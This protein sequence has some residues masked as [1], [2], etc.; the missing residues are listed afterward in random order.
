MQKLM[1]YTVL[2]AAAIGVAYCVNSREPE[3]VAQKLMG[4]YEYEKAIALLAKAIEAD[5]AN[6]KAHVL[7][8]AAFAAID[9]QTAAR[10]ELAEAERLA[11]DDPQIA[12]GRILALGLLEDYAAALALCD[13]QLARRP[14]AAELLANRANLLVSL[15]RHQQALDA[16]D[17]AI[18]EEVSFSPNYA[19]MLAQRG[20]LR[21]LMNDLPG[22]LADL[23]DASRRNPDLHG[24]K[25]QRAVTLALSG[26][27]AEAQAAFAEYLRL[28]PGAEDY[29]QRVL[30]LARE[31]RTPSVV[32]DIRMM[33]AFIAA[34][35]VT[36]SGPIPA[37]QTNP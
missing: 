15:G 28:R 6:A 30:A 19:V 14:K 11:P 3:V 36:S 25:L 8:A 9:L 4:Q 7:Q 34:K 1:I 16:F 2:I 10:E 21:R 37:K 29:L 27:E 33:R 35:A 17:R 13:E 22:S 5:P 20:T 32:E 24:A 18:A 26:R 23:D 12:Q 31:G